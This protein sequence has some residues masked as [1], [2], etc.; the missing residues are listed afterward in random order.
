M[1]Y[2]IEIREVPEHTVVTLREHVPMAVIAKA[3]GEG[4]GEV[5]EAVGRAAATITGMPFA[6]FHELDPVAVDL[7]LGFPVDQILDVGRVHGATLPGGRVASTI[8]AGPYDEVAGAYEALTAWIE[9]NHERPS[10][11]PREVYLNEPEEGVI[12]LT[13]IQMPLA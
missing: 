12:P 9:A 2:E 4:F 10:G 1:R 3:I 11:P 5:A 7:E 13:E 8:H 6:I